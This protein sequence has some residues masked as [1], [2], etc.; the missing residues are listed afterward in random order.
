MVGIVFRIYWDFLAK[1][2]TNPHIEASFPLT[3][4]DS[5]QPPHISTQT[6]FSH[7]YIQ[8]TKTLIPLSAPS[9][10]FSLRTFQI[11]RR[12]S[13][14]F[15]SCEWLDNIEMFAASGS[16]SI[17]HSHCDITQLR[18]S[19]SSLIRHQTS[20]RLL[21]LLCILPPWYT[22]TNISGLKPTNWSVFMTE[23]PSQ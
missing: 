9:L 20:P 1:I 3:T 13:P 17:N 22:I 23:F 8:A 6:K 2:P 4:K 10:K 15:V 11:F 14:F 12:K 21:H 18:S 19:L 5:P 16:P 7:I